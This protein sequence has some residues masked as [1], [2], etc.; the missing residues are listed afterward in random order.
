MRHVPVAYRALAAAIAAAALALVA[1]SVAA[2]M[3]TAEG[4]DGFAET[5]GVVLDQRSYPYRVQLIESNIPGH[6][7]RTL[8][9]PGGSY[10]YLNDRTIAAQY[11]ISARGVTGLGNKANQIDYFS[12]NVGGGIGRD[13]PSLHPFGRVRLRWQFLY[14]GLREHLMVF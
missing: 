5:F 11:Y 7:V 12:V 13:E 1:G 3:V 8:A 14:P 2:Q 4:I 10:S 9:Y 6:K